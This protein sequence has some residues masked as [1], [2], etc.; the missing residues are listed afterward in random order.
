[1]KLLDHVEKSL[2]GLL[3]PDIKE[4][5]LEAQKFKKYLKYL[6]QENCWLK[7]YKWRNKKQI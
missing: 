1:M 7:S 5:V 4:T 6:T 2:S 3:E